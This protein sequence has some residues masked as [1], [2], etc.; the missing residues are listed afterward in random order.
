MW[1]VHLIH[2][3]EVRKEVCSVSC[4]FPRSEQ[5][6]KSCSLYS[7]SFLHSKLTKQVILPGMPKCPQCSTLR[8]EG[9]GQ[10]SDQREQNRG[11][12]YDRAVT[13]LKGRAYISSSV[14]YLTSTPSR[15]VPRSAG[16]MM[17]RERERETGREE[18]EQTCP[19]HRGNAFGR[20]FKRQKQ[21][22]K[23]KHCW[24]FPC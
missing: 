22:K 18:T 3:R 21:N 12:G 4:S 8:W 19:R 9:C 16:E 23:L 20:R 14:Q 10:V 13:L 17:A 15:P 6:K 24:L 11:G 2:F 7:M 5:K 1:F